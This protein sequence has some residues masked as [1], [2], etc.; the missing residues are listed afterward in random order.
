MKPLL[1]I[2]PL[3]ALLFGLTLALFELLTYLASDAVMPAMPVVV[4]ELK[5]GPEY[6]PLA[7][8]LYLLGGVLLQWLIGPLADRY[9]RRPLLLTG[10]AF[11][12]LA[13][14]GTFW[15]HDIGLFNLLRLLQGIG[16]GFVVTVSYPALNEAFSEA[17]AVRMMALLANIALLSPLLGPLVGTLMLQWLDWR[18][19]FVAF[20][21]GAV[22]AWL[23]LYRLMPET[24]GVERR[25]GSRLAF[26]PIHL[27]PLLAGYGQLLSNRRF[28]AG[29]AALGLVGLPLIGWIGLSPV[30]L[31][32][33]EGLSTLA[34]ALWQLP[35]FGGL[36]LGNLIINHIADRHPLPTLVRGA[37]WPYVAGLCLMVVATWVWPSV[38]S[39]VAGLSLYALGLGI[40][41]AVL[42][43][44]TLFASTQ[45]KG[46]V[47]AMLGMITIALLGLGGALLAMIGAGASLLHFAVA[48]SVAGG[49]ALW[50]LWSLLRA[51]SA[52][53]A[54]MP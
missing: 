38:I 45:S 48:A 33:D 12:G 53:A 34:Y 49:L 32:H 20:A 26:T 47:S 39:L 17:D 16:L 1:Y 36:I 29:S 18:W 4:G 6:I 22:V 40:A 31:I 42:Y 37:L 28:V 14:L 52:Q 13:C 7:L 19:L 3:R 9:G 8:N 30:L 54:V 5:A 43:R 44:M 11:F 50:P 41:N 24:L 10:C 21:I 25:D 2:T 23:L 27:L 51:R 15:V 35:V 46:L